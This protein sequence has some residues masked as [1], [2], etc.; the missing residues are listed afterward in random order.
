[1]RA[2]PREKDS[3]LKLTR[4]LWIV[5]VAAVVSALRRRGDAAGRPLPKP[6]FIAGLLRASA[7]V[8]FVPALHPA[9]LAVA[10]LS[11]RAMVV[12]LF[13]IG[14][15]LSREA[16]RSVGLRPLLQ[17]VLLWILMGASTLALLLAKRI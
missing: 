9:G 8:T 6:W 7:A 15:G 17:G 1:V 4:A 16:L 12:A 2:A 3:R 14:A 5:P 13:L 11:Q 10:A